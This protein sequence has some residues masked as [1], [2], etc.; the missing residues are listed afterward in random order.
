M[1][2]HV[3]AFILALVGLIGLGGAFARAESGPYRRLVNFEWDG[4]PD[5][6]SFEIEI[7]QST[8][9]GKLYSFKV[10][11]SAWN[12]RLTPGQYTIRLRALDQRGVPGEWSDT[13]PFPVGLEI[14]Q[15]SSPKPKQEVVG[16]S[17]TEA[18]V[19]LKWNEV[20]GA[21]SYKVQISSTDETFKKE[22]ET[23]TP[24]TAISLPVAKSYNW[25]V[26]ASGLDNVAS[27]S[28]GQG[29]FTLLGQRLAAPKIEQPENEFAREIVW[30]P[31]PDAKKYDITVARHD[32]KRKAWVK[33]QQINDTE[34]T[35][36]P[37]EGNWPGGSYTL[38]VKAKGDLRSPSETAKMPFKLRSGDR[39]P[40]A[41]FAAEIRRSIDRINGWYGIASYLVTQIQ[42]SAQDFDPV[43]PLG[44]SYSA[45]GGTGRVGLGYF[46]DNSPW[47]FLSIVDLS[48]FLNENNQ[49]L[50]SASA[51]ISGVYRKSFGER[52]EVRAQ[53]GG[54]YREQQVARG[55]FLGVGNTRVSEY[56]KGTVAGPHVGA[57][58]WYSFSPR[59]GIQAN[60]HVYMSM[61]GLN[62]P[63]GQT[64]IPSIS[65][66]I[67]FLGSYRF[68]R[69]FTGLVGYTRRE[70]RLEYKSSPLDPQYAGQNNSS[71]LTG[72]Y[73]NFFAEYAF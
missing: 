11:T 13:A 33:V 72:N 29:Y 21:K 3:R 67:G 18:S 12:G 48:G 62:I 46:K 69:R 55:Q 40:A 51:E 65:N 4:D 15:V 41:E 25:S 20:P 27:D 47:G 34:Q 60:A 23:K 36:V 2:I 71:V 42:Y 39:S 61:M 8:K 17:A 28:A 68:N 14:P 10:K 6:K 52:S 22:I 30:T 31:T 63:N 58:Y 45:V 16:N 59:L 9:N 37:V 5:A 66:Q 56:V 64:I 53:F 38:M 7:Q 43:N 73:L 24:S 35:S 54:Y 57:E 70:D 50:T 49:N 44:I 26:V 32:P 19:P 1:V